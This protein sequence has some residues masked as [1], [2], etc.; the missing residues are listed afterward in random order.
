MPET[1]CERAIVLRRRTYRGYDSRISVYTRERGKIDLL[2][3]SALRPGSKLVSHV[4][5][6]SLVDIMVIS[7]RI[8]YVGGSVSRDCF[9]NIKNDYDKLVA[10]G[11]AFHSINRLLHEQ[12]VDERIF[13]GMA[14]FLSLLNRQ[15]AD[16]VWY[17]CLAQLFI[18]KV[19]D[20]LGYGLNVE[21][22]RSCQK[23]FTDEEVI[24]SFADHSLFCRNCAESLPSDQVYRFRKLPFL[25]TLVSQPLSAAV[26][27]T[28][29]LDLEE[30]TEFLNLRTKILIEEI[31]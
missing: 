31:T 4:E 6:L 30:A 11:Q 23:I 12:V 28:K 3:R 9:P 8:A 29:R 2:V 5:P 20:I 26:S 14:S 7:G 17:D 10:A 24:F 22:C 19:I 15:T 25:R 13:D 21:V 1:Y 16:P 27:A 18:Y